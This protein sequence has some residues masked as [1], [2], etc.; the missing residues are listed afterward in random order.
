MYTNAKTQPC[1][2][3]SLRLSEEPQIALSQTG[4]SESIK[5]VQEAG[6]SIL[7]KRWI[8]LFQ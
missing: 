4:E 5:P 1:S 2:Q 6:F 7:E 8:G 3:H